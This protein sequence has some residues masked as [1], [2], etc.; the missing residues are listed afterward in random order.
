[1]RAEISRKKVNLVIDLDPSTE[2]VL[3]QDTQIEQVILN[4]V[5]NAIEA[6]EETPETQRDITIKV[7]SFIW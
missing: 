5:R 3:A 4:L 1:M 7:S 2:W 6:M